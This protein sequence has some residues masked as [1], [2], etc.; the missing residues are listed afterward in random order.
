MI[1][2]FVTK[3]VEEKEIKV[4]LVRDRR[5]HKTVIKYPKP[6]PRDR[7]HDEYDGRDHSE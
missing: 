4:E 7:A 5:Q 2:K 3:A 1:H 6:D